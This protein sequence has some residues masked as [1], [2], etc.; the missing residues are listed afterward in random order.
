MFVGVDLAAEPKRTGL[1]ILVDRDSRIE[2]E[3]VHVGATDED[4]LTA[5]AASTKAGVDVPFGWPRRFAELVEGHRTDTLQAPSDTGPDWRREVLFRATDAEV[6]RTVGKTPLSVAADKIAYPAIRW[7]GIAARLR[8][9]G[10]PVPPDGSGIACEVYPDAAL[11][12]WGLAHVRYKGKEAADSRRMLIEEIS[13]RLPRLDWTHHRDTCAADD[14]ALDA[15]IAAVVARH[16]AIGHAVPPPSHLAEL[17]AEE[18]WIW[19]PETP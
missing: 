5:I 19:V 3:S 12:A 17:A 6:R 13:E 7:A 18:G 14:N 9:R 10:M 8:E 11:A 4:V 16:V 15:V 2:I 1:A